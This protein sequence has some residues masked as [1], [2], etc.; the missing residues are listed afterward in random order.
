MFDWLGTVADRFT[1]WLRFMAVLLA[2]LFSSMQVGPSVNGGYLVTTNQF[3]QPVGSRVEFS[4]SPVDLTVS[5]DGGTVAV[6]VSNT[7]LLYTFSGTLLRTVQ[8]PGAATY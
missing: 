7:V 3:L 5:P 6:T 8:L 1:E 2:S 4:G